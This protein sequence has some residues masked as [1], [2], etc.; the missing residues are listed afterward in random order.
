[1]CQTA[2]AA[3]IWHA[4]PL[5]MIDSVGILL[6]CLIK[7]HLLSSEAVDI[8]VAEEKLQSGSLKILVRQ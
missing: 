2:F 1:M 3:L 6:R 8:F 4:R 5:G 7:S